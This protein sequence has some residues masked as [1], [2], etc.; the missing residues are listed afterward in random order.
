MRT[1]MLWG[2]ALLLCAA[3]AARAADDWNMWNSY[4]FKLPVVER[5][6]DLRGSF[7]TRFRDDM[8]EFFRY[9]F[10]IGP[11][12]HPSRWLTLG[13]QYGNVQ[14]GA[15]GDFHTEHRFMHFLTPKFKGKDVGLKDTPLGDLSVSLQNRLEWR[16]RHHKDHLHTWRYRF[17][18]KVSYPVYKGERVEVSPYVAD[19]FY[20]DLADGAAYNQNRVYGGLSFRILGRVDLDLYYMRLATRSGAGGDWTGGHILGSGIT[21]TF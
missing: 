6:L 9:H 11:D 13:W 3:P 21:Y 15:P 12:Y 14:E 5:R 8:D 1:G 19:A 2:A 18:P 4:A 20:F 7:E 10:Y 17:Y 16:I